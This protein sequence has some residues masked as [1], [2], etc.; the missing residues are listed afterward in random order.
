[1]ELTI[2]CGISH[3]QYEFC[4][5]LSVP[6][7]IVMDLNNFMRHFVVEMNFIFDVASIVSRVRYIVEAHV[8]N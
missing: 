1:M 3:V 8:P 6:Q 4:Q 2:F 5:I 7:I